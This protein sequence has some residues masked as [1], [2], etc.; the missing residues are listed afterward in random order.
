[1]NNREEG[2]R[3]PPV[4]LSGQLSVRV[5]PKTTI[6]AG[7]EEETGAQTLRK[8]NPYAQRVFTEKTFFGAM[9]EYHKFD[10]M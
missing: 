1:M 3:Q 7:F 5:S 6:D 10:K 4:I 8:S 9:N 2:S